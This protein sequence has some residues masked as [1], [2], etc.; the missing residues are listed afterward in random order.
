MGFWVE[1]GILKAFLMASFRIGMWGGHGYGHGYGL[2]GGYGHL[3]RNLMASIRIGLLGR[4][5]HRLLG[6]PHG[7]LNS[8]FN[9]G[10]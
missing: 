10:R 1:M 5:R 2:L 4:H 6:G 7:H 3:D 9:H 8:I